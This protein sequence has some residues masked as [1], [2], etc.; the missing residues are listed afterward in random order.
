MVTVTVN[1]TTYPIRWIVAAN[2]DD[3]IRLM[4]AVEEESISQLARDFEGADFMEK[5]DNKKPGIVERYEGF[6]RLVSISRDNN[7]GVTI[8]TMEAAK[9]E[10]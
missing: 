5:I 6:R 4:V 8:I 3:R 10:S 2:R 9:E 7:E 1:G